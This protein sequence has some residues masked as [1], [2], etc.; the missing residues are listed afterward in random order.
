MSGAVASGFSGR[1]MSWF[2]ILRCGLIQTAIGAIVVL[3]TS[4]YNRVMVVELALPAMLPGALVALHYAIQMSRPR[5]GYGSDM[6]GHRTRWILGGMAV[7]AIGAILAAMAVA[8]METAQTSG[9]VLA[10]FAFVLIGIG[11]GAA[12][13]SLLALLATAVAP[14]RRAA[15]AT[16]TWMMMILGIAVTATLAGQMLDPF[17]GERLIL[18][19]CT[20]CGAAVLLSLIST[21]RLEK[22]RAP[23]P[24][25]DAAAEKPPFRTVFKE[26]WAES[27]A[28]R[29]AIF[30]FVSMLA[31]NTQDLILEP[32]AGLVFGMTP[33][34]STKLTGVQHG[35]VFLGMILVA[36]AGSGPL[37]RRIGSLRGWT[38]WGC[39]GSGVMMAA[40][41]FGGLVGPEYPL[42]T[43]VFLLGVA[44]GA[45]A[46]AA[47]G[48]M[49]KLAGY[50]AKS[51]EGLR[52]GLWGAAQAIAFGIG[53]FLGTA[54]AD[55]A[56][57]L[58]GDPALAYGSVFLFEGSLF[59]ISAVL[60]A[61][62]R[63]PEQPSVPEGMAA[64]PAE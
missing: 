17:S 55:G 9:T 15:S 52:M 46:V 24:T 57:A 6:G 53:G 14:P 36:L 64:A 18:V 26:V 25:G 27:E 28:R 13:T 19:A 60:A 29:F 20:V 58:V 39:V 23:A 38:V 40:L 48:S 7:L 5:W 54:L 42:R 22:P 1:G 63:V 35:G 10:V 16:I 49:M 62:I 47:I 21:I 2:D 32:Y 61:R 59:L 34:E 37:R 51:R 33:G 11:V 44:N 12:G 56:R 45:F 3:T 4:T 43:V 30:V 50:G 8:W 41:A 31:Y